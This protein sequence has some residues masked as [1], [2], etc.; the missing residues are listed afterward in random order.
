MQAGGKIEPGESAI[1]ALRRELDEEIGLCLDEEAPYLGQFTASAANEP[2]HVVIA[3]IFH[4]RVQHNPVIR[5]E[6]AEAIWVSR[7][8]AETMPLAPLTR[9]H[10]LPLARALP[11]SYDSY[12]GRE[13]GGF[14]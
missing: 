10:V 6:I 5:A 12:A 2:Q 7:V 9:E 14:V 13:Q 4:V 3:D 1:C 8:E 11:N